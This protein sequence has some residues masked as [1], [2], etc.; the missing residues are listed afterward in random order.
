MLHYETFRHYSMLNYKGYVY[1][2]TQYNQQQKYINSLI[3][4]IF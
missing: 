4:N 1:K 2:V 3:S